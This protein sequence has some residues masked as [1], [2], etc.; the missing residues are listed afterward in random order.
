MEPIC[1]IVGA[2]DPG[3]IVIASQRPAVIIAA[4]AGVEHLQ[5]QGITP[6]WIVGD[7]DSLGYV[8]EG[9][10]IVQHPVEKDDTDMLLAVRTG[11]EQGCRQFVLYG[12]VGGRLDHTYANLQTLLWMAQRGLSGCM[13]C[14]EELAAVVENGSMA[15][16][17]GMKGTV[18]VFCPDG[19]AEGVTLR[20]LYYP[21]EGASIT[22]AFPIGVSNR[23]TDEA[24]E[25]AVERGRLLVI[26]QESIESYLKRI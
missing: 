19:A 20:G 10:N 6:D 14:G 13:V 2:M 23:F 15:F 21:L 18:S 12:G 9:G 16:P 8:P 22:S 3:A 26:W 11:M 1:Y 24:A 7:F 5:R 17:G 25:I 4:D